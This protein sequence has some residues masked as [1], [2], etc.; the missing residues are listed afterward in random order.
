MPGR[1]QQTLR[2]LRFRDLMPYRVL[3]VLLVSSPY[4]AFNLEQD[5]QLTEQVFLEYSVL[6]LP[7][8]PRFT[9][10]PSAAAALEMLE[11]R[12][13]DLVVAMTG[14]RDVNAFGLE[15]KRRHPGRPVV[16]LALDR[17]ELHDLRGGLDPGAIDGAFLWRGDPK[18]LPALMMYV[19]DR[20]NIDADIAEGQVRVIVVVEDSPD[21]YSSFLGIL[22]RELLHQSRSLHSE[23]G[24]NEILRQMYMKS[25]PK[26]LL[27]TSFDEG[28]ALLERYRRYLLALICDVD[29]PRGGSLDPTAASGLQLVGRARQL[30]PDL[31]ILV[32]SAEVKH[33]HQV[34]NQRA[35]FFHKGSPSLLARLRGFLNETLGFGAFVFRNPEGQE[36]DRAKDLRELKQ[37]LATVPDESIRYHAEHDHFSIWLMARSEFDLAEEIRRHSIFLDPGGVDATRQY[38]L[39]SLREVHRENHRGVVS[40]FSRADFEAEAFARIGSGSLGGKARGVAFLNMRLANLGEA[41]LDGVDEVDVE[42]RVEPD[43]L[44]ILLPKTVVIAVDGFDAFLDRNGLREFAYACT[45]DGELERRFLAGELPEPLV[46]DLGFLVRELDGPL[47]VRS[48]SLLEDSVHQP[49]AGVY[50][51]FML[52]NAAADDAIRTRELAAAVKLV[53]ASTFFA[54]AKAYLR[55]TGH[56][57]EEE[58]MAVMI[59]PVVGRR[60]G[61]RFYPTFSGVAQSFNFYPLEPQRPKDGVVHLAL[62]LGRQ[63][64]EGASALSFSPRHPEVVPQLS[65]PKSFLDQSQRCFYALDLDHCCGESYADLAAAVKRYELAA[66]EEDGTLGA[67]GSVYVVEERAVRDDLRHRGPRLVT[68]N[69][70]LKHRSIPLA[71]TLDRLLD[72]G[73]EGLGGPVEIELAVEMGDWGR[74]RNR[75][76]ERRGPRLY[77]LQMRPLAGTDALSRRAAVEIPAEGCLCRAGSSL[78]NGVDETILDLVFVRRDRWDPARHAVIAA[79]VGELNGALSEEERPYLLIGPGRWGSADEWLGIPVRWSQ[80]SG[81]RVIVEASP[82]GYDIEPSQGT[83]FFQNITS[84][85]IG[86]LSLPAGAEEPGDQAESFLDWAWLESLP[87]HRETDHL[88]WVRLERPLTVMLDGRRGR[89]VVAKPGVLKAGA[90]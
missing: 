82:A 84:L 44:P 71:S 79:E 19:E 63:V 80:I 25:R 34:Q 62:G 67:V 77:V 76:G 33:A 29:L 6:S 10:A 18:I 87:A 61:R 36:L 27:A 65:N 59:Q 41:K 60:H 45:D 66:A 86:Y 70:I 74:P 31:P 23:G 24:A 40:E 85:G 16:V 14:L 49:L 46:D 78:G 4:D 69:N 43:G 56:R 17:K 88:R 75:H 58:K 54:D 9:Q 47:A 32:Q 15:V 8:A 39:R 2:A 35:Q 3:E 89:A 50:S 22:Y 26:I 48:S 51:T 83:H 7:S 53:Y 57:V 30:V 1:R 13:F 64:V 81:V 38:L 11:Q 72:I 20:Q 68:F 52:P 37:K 28:L 55:S 5:G 42:G 73:R 21:D 12:R 90:V